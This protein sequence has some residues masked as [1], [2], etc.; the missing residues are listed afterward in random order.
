MPH[1]EKSVDW[2]ATAAG[3]FKAASCG[4][5]FNQG[6][7]GSMDTPSNSTDCQTLDGVIEGQF[8]D[9]PL[10]STPTPVFLLKTL[11][12]HKVPPPSSI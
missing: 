6:G 1:C 11:R 3:C 10:V 8:H 7:V 12:P 9:Y 4:H 2:V 5:R